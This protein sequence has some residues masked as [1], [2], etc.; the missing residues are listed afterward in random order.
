MKNLL[1]LML[2]VAVCTAIGMPYVTGRVAETVTQELATQV[3]ANSLEYGSLEIID[4]DRRYRSTNAAYKWQ[5]P[6]QLAPLFRTPLEFECVGTHGVISYDYQCRA[7]NMSQYQEFVKTALAGKDPITVGGSVSIF[8]TVTQRLHLEEFTLTN[9]EGQTVAVQPGVIELQTDRELKNFALDGSF[10]GLT[11]NDK[12]ETLAMQPLAVQGSMSINQHQLAIGEVV[13]ELQGMQV[14]SAQDGS[15]NLSGIELSSYTAEDGANLASGYQLN[16]AL[17]EQQ[18]G[19]QALDAEQVHRV[20]DILFG[21]DIAGLDMLQ[22]A[23]VLERVKQLSKYTASQALTDEQESSRNAQAIAMLPELERL[24]QPGLSFSAELDADYDDAAL[25]A[26][27]DLELLSSLSLSDF[28]L[29]SVQPQAFFAKL[30]AEFSNR[31]P[32]ALV[33]ANPAAAAAMAQSHWYVQ[34]GDSYVA[35]ISLAAEKITVNGVAYSVDQF[36]AML[37][38]VPSQ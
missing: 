36:L 16:V 38:Q 13:V 20:K 7:Q 17:F 30:R 18:G 2:V 10:D 29:L 27:V 32:A 15:I 31:L 11:M 5:A 9:D 4:Y 24:L 1:I 26:D 8:G 37:M 28:I 25:T 19:S 6:P 35:E 21:V 33:A 14:T 3:T 12:A 23:E 34:E 22:L